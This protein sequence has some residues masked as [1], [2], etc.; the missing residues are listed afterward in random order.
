M[1]KSKQRIYAQYPEGW[2]HFS[3]YIRFDVAKGQCQC[4]GECGLHS[5]HPGPRRCTERHG[6]DAQYAKGKVTLTTAHLCECEPLC[7]I[8]E[9][10]KAMCNR[11]HLR[12]D[13]ALHAEHRKRNKRILHEKLGQM[14]MLEMSEQA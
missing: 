8:P 9:H 14:T 2:K 12:I 1:A 4:E 13:V 6:E 7:K 10:V 3:N 5:T 11:C